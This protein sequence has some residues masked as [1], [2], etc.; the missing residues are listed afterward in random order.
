MK[1][2][3]IHRG[4]TYKTESNRRVLVKTPTGKLINRL[5]GKRAKQRRCHECN[6]YLNG[7]KQE[8]GRAFLSLATIHRRA[9]RVYGSTICGGCVKTRI[10]D[11]FL[12]DEEKIVKEMASNATA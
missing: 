9:N 7:I 8:R 1:R 2:Q 12:T 6:G 4:R 5:V 3:I 11:A 10:I